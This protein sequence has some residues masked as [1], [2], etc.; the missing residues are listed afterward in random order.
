MYT[1]TLAPRALTR[2]R[3]ASRKPTSCCCCLSTS[4]QWLLSS[5]GDF[6]ISPRQGPE[7]VIS[8]PS[9]LQ[10]KQVPRGIWPV[11]NPWK[12]RW[13]SVISWLSHFIL[14]A[15]SNS[16]VQKK[17]LLS[18]E[19]KPDPQK[20]FAGLHC[21][22]EPWVPERP[23]MIHFPSLFFLQLSSGFAHNLRIK[24]ERKM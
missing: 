12:F 22:A 8:V 4:R 6:P 13:K 15:W 23:N 16:R 24:N 2:H 3:P 21:N 17:R 7:S 5:Q 19:E 1:A 18:S 10:G 20:S 11:Q 14:G 9:A